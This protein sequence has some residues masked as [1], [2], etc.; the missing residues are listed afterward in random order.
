MFNRGNNK[1]ITNITKE[2]RVSTDC[3]PDT[4][5]QKKYQLSKDSTKETHIRFSPKVDRFDH[6]YSNN[7]VVSTEYIPEIELLD[8]ENET[9]QYNIDE[10][11]VGIP[12][13]ELL[14]IVEHRHNDKRVS[15]ENYGNQHDSKDNEKTT[16]Q[17]RLP[18]RRL[19]TIMT[20]A[21]V[22]EIKEK[23][24]IQ[25]ERLKSIHLLF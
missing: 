14:T 4:P 3:T 6:K 7:G 25:G 24:V 23:K 9:N 5:Y 13:S 19:S 10:G 16:K 18:I 22:K 2:S 8:G 20:I 21:E 11:V 12:Q 1:K 17:S 15:I